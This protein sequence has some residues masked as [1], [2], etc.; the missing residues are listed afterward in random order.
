M[1]PP[2]GNVMEF[3]KHPGIAPSAEASIDGIPISVHFRQRPPSRPF[4]CYPDECRK[5]TSTIFR[6]T[7]IDVWQGLQ[8]RVYALPSCIT[9]HHRQVLRRIYLLSFMQDTLQRLT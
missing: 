9:N 7:D 4:F 5:E 3:F 2:H 6:G 1:H 8:K